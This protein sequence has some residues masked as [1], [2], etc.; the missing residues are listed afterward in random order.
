MDGL[1]VKPVDKRKLEKLIKYAESYEAKI[2]EYTPQTA[3]IFK[4]AMVAARTVLEDEKASQ[5]VID[6]T[7]ANLQ[8]ALFD[9]REIPDKSKLEELL[10]KAEEIDLSIYTEESAD[11]FKA[12]LA[13]AAIVYENQEADQETVNAIVGKLQTAM[14]KF[15]REKA[16]YGSGQT[17]VAECYYRGGNADERKLYRRELV[18]VPGSIQR[19]EVGE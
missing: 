15:G 17:G 3:A 8:K 6:Q 13:E 1:E 2:E 11:A 19:G 12:V 18:C 5:A 16:G 14:E 4:D 10:Q 7:Y 9:L